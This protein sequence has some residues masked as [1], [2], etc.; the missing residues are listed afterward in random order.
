MIANWNSMVEWNDV[1]IHLGDFTFGNSP[2]IFQIL[3]G[4][5]ILVLG[6]HDRN[7]PQ[8]YL[9]NGISFVCNQFQ[10]KVFG[11]QVLFSH[12]PV[13][14]LSDSIDVNVHG[15][16]HRMTHRDYSPI[17]G[18]RESGKYRLFTIEEEDYKPVLL[19]EFLN[20]K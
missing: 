3:T 19:E 18:Y 13:P 1:I 12:V 15:H 14:N 6:N 8:W 10:L 4:I 16:F 7:T 5:K 11:K 20:R 2:S 17:P 9:R